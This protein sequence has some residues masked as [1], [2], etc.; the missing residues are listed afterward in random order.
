MARTNITAQVLGNN[1]LN[2]TDATY[3]TLETGAGNGVTFDYD[4]SA[5]V[6]LK[7]ATGGAAVYTFKV[8]TPAAFAAKSLTVPDVTVT[9]A[10]GKTQVYPL[11]AIFKQ[12]DE[13]VYVDCDVAG[14]LLVLDI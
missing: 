10:T 9:L 1:G 5:L 11:S 3:S 13:K 4:A 12:S 14:Q 8:P 2:L 7:N 6:V